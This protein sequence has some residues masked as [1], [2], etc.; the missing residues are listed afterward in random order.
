MAKKKSSKP[1]VSPIK[2]EELDKNK[3]PLTSDE[4]KKYSSMIEN[5][6]K[7][8]ANGFFIL[9][10]KEDNALGEKIEG[11][12]FVNKVNKSLVLRTVINALDVSILDVLAALQ[13][14]ELK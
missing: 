10:N 3:L 7:R 8:E 9:C 13:V 6:G 1:V 12:A 14:K 4:I 2:V 5:V 11:I